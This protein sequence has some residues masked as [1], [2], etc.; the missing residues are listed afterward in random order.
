MTMTD[1]RPPIGL[2]T[3][4]VTLST[5]LVDA[6]HVKIS[7]MN[8][9]WMTD[10]WDLYGSLDEVWAPAN[11]IGNGLGSFFSFPSDKPPVGER[12]FQHVPSTD[13]HILAA[14]D[15]L[16]NS[17]GHSVNQMFALFGVNWAIGGSAYLIGT[18]NGTV[19]ELLSPKEFRIPEDDKEPYQRVL[20]ENGE[21]EDLER[22]KTLVQRIWR[23]RADLTKRPDSP[24]RSLNLVCREL[25]DLYMTIQARLNSRLAANGIFFVPNSMSLPNADIP[26]GQAE[27]VTDPFI[28]RLNYLLN[29][30]LKHKGSAQGAIPILIRG[31][32][33][34]GDQIRHITLDQVITEQEL[35]ERA[36]LRAA[37]AFGFDLPMA[38][39]T[40]KGDEVNHWEGALLRKDETILH[41]SPIAQSFA[42]RG[43]LPVLKA[44]AKNHAAGKGS[45][46]N[47]SADVLGSIENTVIALDHA[48]LDQQPNVHDGARQLHDRGLIHGQAVLDTHQYD[49]TERLEGD[50]YVRWVGSQTKNAR[51]MLYGTE[52]MEDI[53][54]EWFDVGP[55]SGPMGAPKKDDA[56]TDGDEP[57]GI[58]DDGPA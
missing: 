39:Q 7:G 9:D 10:A 31:P 51:L 2:T 12:D 42:S 26:A 5:T 17:P 25:H 37:I 19:W 44:L 3:L 6:P 32:G 47:L 8:D 50:E 55:G 57:K 33:E 53:P 35:Q 34:A 56:P 43:L 29:Q 23:P 22:N 49:D 21:T 16:S 30:G 18:D 54:D 14:W 13:E 27:Q 38:R 28:F 45:I 15:Q 20:D 52:E 36:E 41:Y 58:P 48:A 4:P 1:S 40:Q 11:L 24:M 46:K